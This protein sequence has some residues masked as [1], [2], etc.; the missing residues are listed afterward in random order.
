MFVTERR[1]QRRIK[2]KKRDSTKKETDNNTGAGVSVDQFQS[3]QP[4][5]VPQL[6]G[7]LTHVRIWVDQV[8]VGHFSDLTY[9]HLMRS[10]IQEETLSLK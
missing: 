6:S 9:A 3:A 1:S 8:M 2:W 7:K 5:L 10:A 4:V